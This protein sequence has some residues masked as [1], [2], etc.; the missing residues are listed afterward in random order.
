MPWLEAFYTTVIITTFKLQA[1]TELGE[2]F[3]LFINQ[4]GI[5]KL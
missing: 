3:L 1:E 2:Q 4:G 5:A